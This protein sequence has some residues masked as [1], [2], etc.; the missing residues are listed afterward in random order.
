MGKGTLLA[1]A[2][3]AGLI[4][5]T[6]FS[7][8]QPA[9]RGVQRLSFP[10]YDKDAVT[11]ITITGKNPIELKKADGKWQV[12]DGKPA[13]ETA[14]KALLEAIG[15]VDSTDV[16]TSHTDKYA[17]M[18][19]DD[20][21]GVHVVASAGAKHVA[22]FTVGKAAAG[23]TNIRAG[24]TVY[25][26]RGVFPY[27]FSKPAAQWHQLKLFTDALD[28]VSRVEVTLAGA[29]T[30]A[31]VKKDN[32][33][34]LEDTKIVPDGFRFDPDMARTLASSLVN[35]SAK[36]ILD[37]DPGVDTTKLNGPTDTFTFTGKDGS[38]REVHLGA[39]L[40][41]K[42][43]YAKVTGRDDVYTLVEITAKNLR[44][45]P[46]DFRALTLMKLENDKVKKL[47]IVSDKTKLILEKDGT[48]WKVVKSSETAPADFTFD[49]NQVTSRLSSIGNTRGLRLA[50][51]EER[52]K[53]PLAKPTATLTMTLDDGKEATLVLGGEGKDTE[54]AT[55]FVF[56]RGNVDNEIYIVSKYLVD[57][58]AGGLTT[59]KKPPAQPQGGGGFDASQLA[60]LPPDVRAQLMKQMQ[61]RQGM[62]GMP[63]GFGGPQGGMSPH[64]PPPPGASMAK[65]PPPAAP[66][67]APK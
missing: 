52:A 39:S 62:P 33:W 47:S 5:V 36:E 45:A 23:A 41:D 54:H 24:D 7:L 32:K 28:D 8:R 49:P 66:A 34:E 6:Y 35:L 12:S 29:P 30:Y 14:V 55:P 67:A 18:E 48:G 10:Q 25:A 31:L 63:P 57:R 61:G 1:A 46:T 44:K 65:A 15:K 53:S 64:M 16:L 37:K 21:K 20:E 26:V 58:L 27:A 2:V 50:T 43:V 19:V 3:F 22:E 60:N 42:S 9:E 38:K 56:A 4:A 40:A 11:G 13:D 51:W 59:F 17:A